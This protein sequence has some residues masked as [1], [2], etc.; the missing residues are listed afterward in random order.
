[1]N[2][3]NYK[4]EEVILMEIGNRIQQYRISLNI[5]QLELAQKCNISLKTVARIEMGYDTKVS[6][7]IKILNEIGIAENLEV[8]IPEPQPDYK[9]IF[10][11][12]A[13]RKRARPNKK[14]SDNVWVWE[15]DKEDGKS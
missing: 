11:E 13:I 14:K 15:E 2:I 7:L 1:M 3:S 8:L 10:E 4:N 6:N 5:T 9:A 12:K